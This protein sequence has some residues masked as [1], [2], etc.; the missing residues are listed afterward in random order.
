VL[1]L[2]LVG[3][4]PKKGLEG[5]Q[6]PDM[7]VRFKPM[8]VK[9]LRNMLVNAGVISRSPPDPRE[10]FDSGFSKDDSSKV[11]AKVRSRFGRVTFWR[12]DRL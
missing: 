4:N 7:K 11:L 12:T 8:V 3:I 5:T 1:K 10:R 6:E 2:G 9:V